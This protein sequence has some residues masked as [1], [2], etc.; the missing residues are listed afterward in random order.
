M[1]VTQ[2][3]RFQDSWRRKAS[4]GY[5][6]SG[7]QNAGSDPGSALAS[8][9][10]GLGL[11]VDPIHAQSISRSVAG[12]RFTAPAVEVPYRAP[13]RSA[14]EYTALFRKEEKASEI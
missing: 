13:C 11:A 14:V 2:T 8:C 10:R 6:P 9:I 7:G 5:E 4:G 1:H 3:P 12:T